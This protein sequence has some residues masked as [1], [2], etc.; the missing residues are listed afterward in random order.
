MK[1]VCYNKKKCHNCNNIVK[2]SED[3]LMEFEALVE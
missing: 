3:C 1:S 2:D